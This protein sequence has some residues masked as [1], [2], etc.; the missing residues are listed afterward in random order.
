MLVI[1]YHEKN[2]RKHKMKT[3]I[4]IPR[5]LAALCSRFIVFR[6]EISREFLLGYK[7]LDLLEHT[8]AERICFSCFLA[9]M[10]MR[11]YTNTMIVHGIQN[12][13]L[14]EITAYKRFT[15]NVQV[16]GLFF[17]VNAFSFVVYS[18]E[19][20]GIYEISKGSQGVSI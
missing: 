19:W 4:I 2:G 1:K 18:C 14:D 13:T 20:I 12:E 5:V 15:I 7:A 9:S 11:I 17:N 10:K 3:P 16:Y 8:L 6:S